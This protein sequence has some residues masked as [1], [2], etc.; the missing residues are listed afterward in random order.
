MEMCYNH[1]DICD[2]LNR[3]YNNK[4][5][6]YG[7]SFSETYDKFGI[8]AP[9]IRINDKVNRLNAIVKNDEMLVSETIIDTLMDLANYSIMTVMELKKVEKDEL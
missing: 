5:I 3:I 9:I 1:N 2:E 7:N 8:I 6:D 4:N